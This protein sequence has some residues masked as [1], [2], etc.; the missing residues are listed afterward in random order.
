MVLSLSRICA[1]KLLFT[2]D[3]TLI[4]S[5]INTSSFVYHHFKC[6]HTPAYYCI[7]YTPAYYQV[8]YGP[9][10]QTHAYSCILL[11]TLHSC[12]LSSI[13]LPYPANSCIFLHTLAYSCTLQHTCLLVTWSMLDLLR[14][15][16]V[17][18][19]ISLV[20]WPV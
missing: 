19:L 2:R 3:I 10:L 1:S 12:I 20:S 14:G 16:F 4:S 15:A 13:L 5:F 9:I 17:E 11:Y 18:F 8:Y 6:M 7:L